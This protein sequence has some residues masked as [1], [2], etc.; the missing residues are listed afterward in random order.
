MTLSKNWT[1]TTSKNC[2]C[3]TS[4]VFGTVSTPT[5][6]VHSNGHVNHRRHPVRTMGMC[7]CAMTRTMF[8]SSEISI[9]FCTTKA[10][11]ICLFA[12]TTLSKNKN[13]GP[14]NSFRH[15]RDHDT[16]RCTT[17]GMPTLSKN[18]T[19]PRQRT[20]TAEPP[21]FSHRLA[22]ACRSKKRQEGQEARHL[23]HCPHQARPQP[24]PPPPPVVTASTLRHRPSGEDQ[25]LPSRSSMA[26]WCCTAY[27]ST[28]EHEQR[29]DKL[30]D[31]AIET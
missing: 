1:T 3:E 18:W 24:P 11:G 27:R 30:G 12:T 8:C 17:T 2:S 7:L 20:A 19:T 31:T 15:C 13:S 5:P 10:T 4:S 22:K 29:E 21:Q 16:C 25:P 6:D 9:G 23:V 14:P 26:P 28:Q